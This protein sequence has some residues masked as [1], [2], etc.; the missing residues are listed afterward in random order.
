MKL[1]IGD[2]VRLTRLDEMWK[3]PR[4]EREAVPTDP[5]VSLFVAIGLTRP[6]DP[7]ELLTVVDVTDNGDGGGLMHE[8]CV[9]TSDGQVGWAWMSSLNL[10]NL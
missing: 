4:S 2:I 6:V 1:K 8:A 9:M 10:V 3:R 7:S 5:Y